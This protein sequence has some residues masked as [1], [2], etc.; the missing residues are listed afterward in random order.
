MRVAVI[1][2]ERDCLAKAFERFLMASEACQDR[3]AI[4]MGFCEFGLLL[5]RGVEARQR[6]VV[7]FERMQNHALIEQDLWRRLAHAHRF[8]DEPKRL[9]WL[10]PGKLDNAQHLQGVEMVRPM[11]KYLRIETLG[12]AQIALLMQCK[13]LREG[14]RHLERRRLRQRRRR[15]RHPPYREVKKLC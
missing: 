7:A 14:L 1:V 9:G 12:L 5:Q 10:A 3:T 6:L 4:I 13:R 2:L 15:H 8:G 11:R